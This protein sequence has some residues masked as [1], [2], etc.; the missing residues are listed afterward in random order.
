MTLNRI[1]RTEGLVVVCGILLVVSLGCTKSSLKEMSLFRGDRDSQAGQLLGANSRQAEDSPAT[2]HD[3]FEAAK[4]DSAKSGKPI[5]AVFT[6]SDWCPPCA[7]LKKEVFEQ[8]EFKRWASQNASLLEVD[9]P[10]RSAQLPTI[11]KQNSMLAEKYNIQAY[12]TVLFLTAQGEVLG[13]L[14]YEKDPEVWIES[15]EEILRR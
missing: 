4:S 14:G 1:C 9:F 15:A 12:P 2:W 10:K 11:K 5:L 13:K 7:K 6:G 3:S 8:E